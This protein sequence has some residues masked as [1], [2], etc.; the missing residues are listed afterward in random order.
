LP[1]LP[2]LCIGQPKPGALFAVLITILKGKIHRIMLS[3]KWK[4]LKPHSLGSE[5]ALV[6][7]P[8]LWI[9]KGACAIWKCTH[10]RDTDPHNVL[11]PF[12]LACV[13]QPFL[14]APAASVT[15]FSWA[16]QRWRCVS[17]GS[18]RWREL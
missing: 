10:V 2:L 5:R 13:A 4:R 17:A 1:S 3:R 18:R 11:C 14:V 7:C 6:G 8:G 9:A 15:G 16:Q 12:I